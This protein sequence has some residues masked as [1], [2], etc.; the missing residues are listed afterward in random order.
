MR[1]HQAKAAL[2]FVACFLLG[3]G[4]TVAGCG[5]GRIATYV[6]NGQVKVDGRPADGAIVVFC[7]LD[8]SAEVV[9]QA[10]KYF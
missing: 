1:P 3:I 10:S 5:D 4:A 6:V 7:P 8:P 9:C 2:L